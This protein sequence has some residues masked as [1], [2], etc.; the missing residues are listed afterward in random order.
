M[1]RGVPGTWTVLLAYGLPSVQEVSPQ[2]WILVFV[3]EDEDEKSEDYEL[4]TELVLYSAFC[5]AI[6]HI[7]PE[8]LCCLQV[9]TL[10][11]F[12]TRRQ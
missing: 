6:G 11:K 2:K 4:K 1:F 3:Q 8:G 9:L 12:W 7:V 10:A 5:L